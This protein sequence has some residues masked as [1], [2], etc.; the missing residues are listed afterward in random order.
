MSDQILITAFAAPASDNARVHYLDANGIECVTTGSTTDGILLPAGSTFLRVEAI[1]GAAGVKVMMTPEE[2]AMRD[3]VNHG[4]GAMIDGQHVPI[5]ELLRAPEPASCY[6]KVLRD[7]LA[8]YAAGVGWAIAEDCGEKADTALAAQPDISQE[9]E[10]A[11]LAVMNA[12]DRQLSLPLSA[13]AER[14]L[15]KRRIAV[16]I[17]EVLRPQE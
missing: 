17:A 3:A 4:T 8:F 6:V 12:R 5:E 1:P 15:L 11:F 2:L 9:V 16:A 14:N 13:W 10:R 7:A